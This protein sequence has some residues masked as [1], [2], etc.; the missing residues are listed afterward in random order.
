LPAGK[1]LAFACKDEPDN[2]RSETVEKKG[3]NGSNYVEVINLEKQAER[4]YGR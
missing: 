3:R 1:L 4:N 2:G